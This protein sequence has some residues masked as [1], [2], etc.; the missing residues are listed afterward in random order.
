[1]SVTSCVCC[2]KAKTQSEC[3]ICEGAVCKK[4]LKILNPDS[5]A[6]LEEVAEELSHTHYCDAC[7]DQVVQPQLDAYQEVMERAQNVF[8]FFITQRKEVPFTKRTKDFFKI[9]QCQDR[10]ETI[11]RMAFRS[12]Q[13]GHNALVDVE[14]KAE[15][16]RNGAYQTSVWSGT[17]N[18]ASVDEEKLERQVRRNAIYR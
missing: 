6:F 5:F 16:V 11:L 12:A 14:V 1:M 2:Q 15:K 7:F 3:A 18:A 4:C 17:G 13:L 8:V 9:E 10:D